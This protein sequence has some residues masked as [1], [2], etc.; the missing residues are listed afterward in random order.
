[1][2]EGSD[3]DRNALLTTRRVSRLRARPCR[4]LRAR[5]SFDEMLDPNIWWGA[6]SRIKK[7]AWGWDRHRFL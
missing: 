5:S 3:G 4:R 2:P 1:V 6:A 7:C